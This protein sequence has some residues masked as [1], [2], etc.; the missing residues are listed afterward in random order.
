MR[1]KK[2]LRAMEMKVLMM[3][4]LQKT[5][6]TKICLMKLNVAIVQ[7]CGKFVNEKAWNRMLSEDSLMQKNGLELFKIW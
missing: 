2:D 1:K 4:P 7:D 3:I 6:H 5:V